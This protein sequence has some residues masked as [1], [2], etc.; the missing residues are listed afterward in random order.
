[1]ARRRSHGRCPPPF[2]AEGFGVDSVE[3][4]RGGGSAAQRPGS[5]RWLDERGHAAGAR[6]ATPAAHLNRE[7]LNELAERLLHP[8]ELR[9]VDDLAHIG[10]VA[11]HLRAHT[12]EVFPRGAPVAALFGQRAFDAFPGLALRH[13]RIIP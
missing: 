11:L 8:I 4:E 12:V 2:T 3:F 9:G 5:A 6:T 13:T 7:F 1:P 10:D